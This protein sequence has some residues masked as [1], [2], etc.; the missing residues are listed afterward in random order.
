MGGGSTKRVWVNIYRNKWYSLI[1]HD[2]TCYVRGSLREVPVPN[3][4]LWLMSSHF[5]LKF[6]SGQFYY[7]HI[8]IQKH[9]CES[10]L[11]FKNMQSLSSTL[12]DCISNLHAQCKP[13]PQF[14]QKNQ[15]NFTMCIYIMGTSLSEPLT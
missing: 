5:S 9:R 7:F 3:T 12:Q 8:H 15:I 13:K 11:K 2:R 6:L 4:H 14:T 1:S 10:I